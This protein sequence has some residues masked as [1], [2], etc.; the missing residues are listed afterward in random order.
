VWFGA[1]YGSSCPIRLD[2]V[3]VDTGQERAVVHAVTVVPGGTGACTDDANP[4]SY[5]IALERDR[6]PAGPFAIQLGPTDPPAGVPEERTVVDADLSV[7]GAVATVDQVGPDR[8]LIDASQEPQPLES[9][10][11]IEPG[12]PV[13]FRMFVHCGIAVLGE[14]NDVWWMTGRD[15]VPVPRAWSGLVDQESQ[16]IVVDVLMT[17]GPDPTLTATA[18]GRAVAYHP[19]AP[20][21]VPGCD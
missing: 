19:V 2:D 11:I 9:G 5:V 20:E 4:H 13:P 1:V 7:A 15:G 17:S 21:D 10:A 18:G 16:T 6:L 12:Y 8:A 3:V 14:L